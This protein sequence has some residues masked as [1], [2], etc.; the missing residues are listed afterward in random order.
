MHKKWLIPIVLSVFICMAQASTAQEAPATGQEGQASGQQDLAKKSQ[1]PV[2]NM[3]SL[4]IEY[5][6]HD[7]MAGGASADA[8]MLK[9]VYPTRIGNLNLINRFIIPYL[10][11]DANTNADGSDLGDITIPGETSRES[12]LG[13]IQYQ[14]FFTAAEPGKI[15]W[16]LG[17]VFELPTN[18]SGLGSDKWSAGAAAL[19]LTMPGKWVVGGLMQNMWSFAGPG[20]EPSVNKFTFQYF[21][22]YNISNGWYLTSSPIM[23][24]DWTK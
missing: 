15:V 1:N 9:P 21:L 22:N 18:T 23:T 2:G 10:G 4:P 16:G 11:I 17:P 8:I 5:W 3:I 24:A 13:N 19:V 6:H 12:G 20:D 7:G 14:G